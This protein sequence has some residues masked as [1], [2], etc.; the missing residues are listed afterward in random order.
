MATAYVADRFTDQQRTVPNA[1]DFSVTFSFTMTAAFIINDTVKLCH[2]PGVSCAAG[3]NI[4]DWMVSI[5]A[6]DSS[7]G[8]VV[9]L[10][11]SGTSNKFMTTTAAGQSSA[12]TT[13]YANAN[14]VLGVLPVAYTTEDSFILKITTAPSGTPTTTGTI[15]GYVRFNAIGIGAL[16]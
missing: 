8:S 10:G 6:L 5:P 16:L 3:V 11:D 12:G 7:T 13:L 1:S 4:L 2:I 9:T 15:K 14:G